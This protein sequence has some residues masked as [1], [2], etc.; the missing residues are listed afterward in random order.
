MGGGLVLIL[1]RAITAVALGVRKGKQD[2]A[3]EKARQE[4][5]LKEEEEKQ[6][7]LEDQLAQ[8]DR[9]AAG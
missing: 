4:Q 8:A 2:K 3:Q 9:L 7:Q 1:I 5:A 6:K